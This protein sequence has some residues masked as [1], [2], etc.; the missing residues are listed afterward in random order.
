MEINAYKKYEPIFGS[1]YIKELLGEGSFGQVFRIEKTEL[2]IKYS[3]A[4]KI[5]TVPKN[6]SE[7]KSIMADGMSEKEA[8]DY[9]KGVVQD[10]VRESVLMSK[11]K[12]I[13]NIV[14]YEDH[15]TIE[16]KD[17]IGWDILIK[18]ELLTPLHDYAAEHEMTTHD[19]IKLGI[20]ICKA[21]EICENNN[22]IHRDVKPENIFVSSNGDYKLG[23][24]GI[25]RIMEKTISGMSRKGTFTYMAPEIYKGN[26]YGSNI[27]LYSLGIVMYRFLNGNRAPFFPP[28]P[29]P[30]TYQAREDALIKR[31]KGAMIPPPQNADKFLSDVILKACEYNPKKR[32]SSASQLRDDLES[33]LKGTPNAVLTPKEATAPTEVIETQATSLLV[34]K[35]DFLKKHKTVFIVIAIACVVALGI[36]IYALSFN[37]DSSTNEKKNSRETQQIASEETSST[38]STESKKVTGDSAQVINAIENA[39]SGDIIYIESGSY[40]FEQ[41]LMIYQDNLKIV[42]EGDTKPQFDCGIYIGGTNIT[43]DNIGLNISSPQKAVEEAHGIMVEGS[44][45]TNLKNVDIKMD[46]FSELILYG[47]LLYSEASIDE[48]DIDVNDIDGLANIAIGT[49]S[50]FSLTNSTISSNDVG[51]NGFVDLETLSDSN[52]QKLLQE[53]TFHSPTRILKNTSY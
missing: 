49:N 46:Y 31:M 12:G 37:G 21:L 53:N 3:A 14:S 4:L 41:P 50:E 20:D 29:E 40:T 10:I 8:T 22:I 9:Y 38:A 5:I 33:A 1:W 26:E 25:A 43:I 51:I 24:F 28:A 19:V 7:V 36:S 47:L 15:Q 6:S 13:S 52:I 34:D 45:V 2:G 44:G 16:H 48:C 27:D 11:L 23:D 35:T 30:I 18:M 32:Y 39:N 17:D 42:G